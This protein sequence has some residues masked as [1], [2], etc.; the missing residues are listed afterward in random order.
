MKDRAIRRQKEATKRVGNDSKS[1]GK[2]QRRIRKRWTGRGGEAG[3]EDQ[4][5]KVRHV[6]TRQ[7]GDSINPD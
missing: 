3:G 4:G 1:I 5:R 6:T 7:R 2:E